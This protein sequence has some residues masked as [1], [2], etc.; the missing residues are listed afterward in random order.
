MLLFAN[1]LTLAFTAAKVRRQGEPDV[2]YWRV[3]AGLF[4]LISLDEIA[5]RHEEIS[6]LFDFGGVLY[7]GWA[8]RLGFR[9]VLS[10]LTVEAAS[11]GG[12]AYAH[13]GRPLG[14]GHFGHGADAGIVGA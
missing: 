3:L 7:S 9:S 12:G 8:F 13:I 6:N 5:Q 4:V 14:S 1:A 11:W 2:L 10:T